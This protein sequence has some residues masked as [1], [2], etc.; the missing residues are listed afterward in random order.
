MPAFSRQNGGSLSDEQINTIVKGLLAWKDASKLP[1]APL[2]PYS[3]PLGDVASGKAAFAQSCA[4]CHGVDGTGGK[5]GSV[6]DR[7]YLNLVSNQYL[8]TVT[9]AGRPEL[10]CPDFAHRTPGSPMS[11]AAISDITAWLV[12][13]RVNE[14]NQPITPAPAKK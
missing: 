11:P 3:A 5:A 1:S 13:Q 14:F 12:S 6:V 8:R 9:I 7:D 4:S 10:G 2:P